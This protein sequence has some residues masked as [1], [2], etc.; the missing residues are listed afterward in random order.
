MLISFGYNISLRLE[1]E[2]PV[3]F[4]LKLHPS[5]CKD[6]VCGENFRIEPARPFE[7]YT[8]TSLLRF[9]DA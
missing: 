9:A 5:R 3:F 6:L 2:C 4:C 1:V 7:E 8:R